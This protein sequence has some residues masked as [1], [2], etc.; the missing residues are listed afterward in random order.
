[1][2]AEVRRYVNE[3]F[4]S[5]LKPGWRMWAVRYCLLVCGWAGLIRVG[6]RQCEN[7]LAPSGESFWVP[8][9]LAVVV[10][11]FLLRLLQGFS[12]FSTIVIYGAALII[13]GLII[14]FSIGNLFA[15]WPFFGVMLYVFSMGPVT[16]RQKLLPRG[17]RGTRRLT[18]KKRKAN[19]KK[20]PKRPP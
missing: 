20:K 19:D 1:M 5:Q 9:S 15:A 13:S 10:G 17:S 18:L 12:A 14:D 11:L 2:L 4:S 16:A 6:W 8:E 7:T 3:Y